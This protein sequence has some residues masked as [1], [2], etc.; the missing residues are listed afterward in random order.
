MEWSGVGWNRKAAMAEKLLPVPAV[1]NR[2]CC[3][4]G[5]CC[6]VSARLRSAPLPRRGCRNLAVEQLVA[7]RAVE[8]LVIAVLPWWR[9]GDVERL[10]PDPG[11][12]YLD[13]CRDKFA[14][15][16]GPDIG[17]RAP[18]HDQ[19]EAF[20]ASFIDDRQGTELAAIP[21][22]QPILDTCRLISRR[23]RLSGE[24]DGI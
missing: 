17:R 12:P 11:Q 10:Y 8:A 14:A 16:I 5:L 18:R 20:A 23:Q 13:S 4:G 24:H 9:R 21:A 3:E 2:G 7:K 6:N 15:I 22:S 19:G 1:G